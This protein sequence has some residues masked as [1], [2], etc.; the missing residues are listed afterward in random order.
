MHYSPHCV[1]Y[2]PAQDSPYGPPVVQYSI[3]PGM[4]LRDYFAA[5]ALGSLVSRG[6]FTETVAAKLAYD[7]ADAMLKRREK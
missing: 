1:G 7:Y 3:V 6:S 4:S 2:L 5:Q